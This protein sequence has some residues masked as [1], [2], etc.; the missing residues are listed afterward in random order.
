MRLGL[1]LMLVLGAGA[2]CAVPPSPIRSWFEPPN[3]RTKLSF[4]APIPDEPIV[5]EVLGEGPLARDFERAWEKQAAF[6][7]TEKAPG[8]GGST[9]YLFV[10]PID[11]YWGADEGDLPG[12]WAAAVFGVELRAMGG[13]EAKSPLMEGTVVG[14][15]AIPP[16]GFSQ[17]LQPGL[18]RMAVAQAVF[19]LRR[20][21]AA[22]ARK[23]VPGKV[24]GPPEAK[25]AGP[26]EPARP[27]EPAEPAEPVPSKVEGPAEPARPVEPPERATA[28]EPPTRTATPGGKAPLPH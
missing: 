8:A 3:E 5:L 21:I 7:K 2:G 6:S 28:P 4:R 13:E 19:D 9:L 12:A 11:C 22:N 15:V 14:F 1:V 24:E 18:R 17:L 20:A 23:P 16:E 27:A 25:P 26:A 10:D